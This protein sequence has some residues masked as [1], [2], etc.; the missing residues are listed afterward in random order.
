MA[1]FYTPWSP[2]GV[3]E[4]RFESLLLT[5]PV[6]PDVKSTKQRV[7]VFVVVLR[8]NK[9]KNVCSTRIL[10]ARPSQRTLLPVTLR[11]PPPLLPPA[12]VLCATNH[13]QLYNTQVSLYYRWVKHD[14]YPAKKAQ[15]KVS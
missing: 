4:D 5:L 6:R 7:T 9:T 14:I 10:T 1:C 3:G 15:E 12:C 13:F 2:L 8:K 11:L